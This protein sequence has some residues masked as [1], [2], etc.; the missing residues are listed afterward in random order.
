MSKKRF[1]Q[2][3]EGICLWVPAT[4]EK[5][6]AKQNMGESSRAARIKHIS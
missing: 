6:A 4:A 1:V 2:R 5:P 3:F